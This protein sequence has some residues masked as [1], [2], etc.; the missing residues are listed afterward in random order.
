[1]PEDTIAAI[2]TPLGEGALAVIRVSGANA[3][4]VADRV[5]VP[6]G[7]SSLK[8]S[9]AIRLV[10]IA[11]GTPQYIATSNSTSCTCSLVHPFANAPLAW[12]R[13]SSGLPLAAVIPNMTRLRMSLERPERS[14]TSP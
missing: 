12:T 10:S 11:A 9:A 5:F 13:N 8:I 6:G 14:Q 7:R 2:A 4:A 3:F 1:M